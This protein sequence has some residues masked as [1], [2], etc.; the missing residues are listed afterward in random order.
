MG[1]GLRAT[2]R[3]GNPRPAPFPAQSGR[4]RPPWTGR[5]R[6]VSRVCA[7]VR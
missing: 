4:R 1:G 5:R 6:S 7:T 2:G 3:D